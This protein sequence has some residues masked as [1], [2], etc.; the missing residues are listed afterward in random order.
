MVPHLNINSLSL[1]HLSH[2]PL[3][4]HGRELK[5]V[6]TKEIGSEVRTTSISA[7]D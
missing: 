6:I 5:D 7:V 1:V 3:R 4:I 2:V